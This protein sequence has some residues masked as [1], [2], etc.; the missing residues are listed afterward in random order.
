MLIWFAA[1]TALIL[2]ELVTPTFI[3]MFFGFG[4]WGAALMSYL[5]PGVTQEVIAFILVTSLSLFLFRNKMKEVFQGVQAGRQKN[6]VTQSFAYVGKQAK[7]HKDIS[8]QQEGEVFVGG[9]YWRATAQVAIAKDA[10]IIIER[11]DA[12]DNLLLIVKPIQD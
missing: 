11:Q 9:S 1:G 2:L 8:P 7:V 12:D 6:P 5:Y 4:A 3:L 10:M